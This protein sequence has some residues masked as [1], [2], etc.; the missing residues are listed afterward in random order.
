[1]LLAF[2]LAFTWYMVGLIWFVQ[3]VHYPMMSLVGTEGYHRYQEA[4]MRRTTWAVG[5]AMLAEAITA[6]ALVFVLD[7]MA[8]VWA[9]RGL[10]I[11]AAVWIVTAVFS[12]PAHGRLLKA[13]DEEAHRRLVATNW[14]RTIGWTARGLVSIALFLSV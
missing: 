13:F 12:V 2:H 8:V 10:T 11:L 5:F 4:H 7:G 6:L 3:L 1:M 9:W 14:L